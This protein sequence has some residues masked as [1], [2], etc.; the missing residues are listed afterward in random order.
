MASSAGL[1]LRSM[2]P[3]VL[4]DA[5]QAVTVQHNVP[6]TVR[7]AHA[8]LL[9]LPTL[10]RQS[11]LLCLPRRQSCEPERDVT[12]V[13]VGTRLRLGVAENAVPRWLINETR[14]ARARVPVVVGEVMKGALRDCTTSL[15]IRLE[16][17]CNVESSASRLAPAAGDDPSSC[18]RRRAHCTFMWMARQKFDATLGRRGVAQEGMDGFDRLNLLIV[19]VRARMKIGP[20]DRE[21][22]GIV[23]YGGHR[24]IHVASMKVIGGT[25]L[26]EIADRATTG[27]RYKDEIVRGQCESPLRGTIVQCLSREQCQ[28]NGL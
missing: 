18:A 15:A 2:P 22:E 20:G 16:C 4:P 19:S 26:G 12:G 8:R 13:S 3:G 11:D 10:S 17:D 1:T 23:P 6:L 7:S 27:T 9:T 25:D 5:I 28:L 24:L 14:S 21:R